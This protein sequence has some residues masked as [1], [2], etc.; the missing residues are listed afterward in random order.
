MRSVGKRCLLLLHVI[1]LA[2]GHNSSQQC[3]GWL[4]GFPA[5]FCLCVLT[6]IG[7]T[8]CSRLRVSLCRDFKPPCDLL[9]LKRLHCASGN[10][11]VCNQYTVFSP[12]IRRLRL[13]SSRS[14]TMVYWLCTNARPPYRSHKTQ[15]K[16][17]GGSEVQ[18]RGDA[19]RMPHCVGHQ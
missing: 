12:V 9:A 8:L 1:D 7:T 19:R 14:F 18:R 5:S 3:S 16:L 11:W 6:T 13:V 17:D 4:G 10:S 2:V 15:P